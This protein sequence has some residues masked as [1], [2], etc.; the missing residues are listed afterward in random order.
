[1]QSAQLRDALF[2]A[3]A[4]ARLDHLVDLDRR[5]LDDQGDARMSDAL[6]EAEILI[7]SWGAPRINAAFL[8]RA[9]ALRAVIHAAGSVKHW[10]DPVLWERGI[11]VSTAA[12]ANA[13]PV[14]E[15]TL[16]MIL[17]SGKRVLWPSAPS[18]RGG[19]AAAWRPL[20]AA[21]NY[22]RT[23]GIVGAS[24]TGRQVMDLLMGFDVN[25]VVYDPHISDVE[26]ARWGVRATSME[27]LAEQV[28]VL[29]VHAPALPATRHM[30]NSHVLARM[31]DGAVLINTSRGSLIDHDALLV[32]LDRR[33]LFAVLDVT[34]PEPLPREHRL[35]AH[36]QVIV[37]PHIAGSIGNELGRLG[38]SVL[39]E[40][41]RLVA[42]VPLRH[43]V[44]QA[45]LEISA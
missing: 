21:G 34:E 7:T 2:D 5:I 16:A 32:E 37:T 20:Q 13:Q 10:A 45:V 17:L 26:V 27:E 18:D 14:A 38:E 41:E 33:P 28:D 25:I 4:I 3:G 40:I 36:P 42:G 43:E 44:S 9:P 35:R 29:S 6:A 39:G 19:Q 22:G 11:V 31:R 24:R 23:V 15:Y 30:V 8:E 1:M 12:A